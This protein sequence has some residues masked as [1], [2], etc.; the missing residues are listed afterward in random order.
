MFRHQ[1]ETANGAQKRGEG[2]Q[3]SVS[4]P[5]SG[6]NATSSDATRYRSK[7]PKWPFQTDHYSGSK[8]PSIGSLLGFEHVPNADTMEFTPT[9]SV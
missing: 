7:V 4:M 3:A 6:A 5:T 9:H 1:P 2:D 8:P